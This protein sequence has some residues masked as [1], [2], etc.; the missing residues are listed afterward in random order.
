M[1]TPF[2]ASR[3]KAVDLSHSA[4]VVYFA[5]CSSKARILITCD[6]YKILCAL[7]TFQMASLSALSQS[8]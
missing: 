8:A 5:L 3:L 7:N 2:W 6:E 4:V 1:T